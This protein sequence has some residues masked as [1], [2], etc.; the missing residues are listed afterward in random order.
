MCIS[1]TT[2]SGCIFSES[3]VKPRVSEKSAVTY[4]RSPPSF[5]CVTSRCSRMF[6]T[7]DWERSFSINGFSRRLRI[8]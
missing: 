1:R 5:S 7:V 6:R 4:F 8:I 3:D 2:S